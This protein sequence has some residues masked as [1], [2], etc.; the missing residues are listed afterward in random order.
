MVPLVTA[1]KRPSN[2]RIVFVEPSVIDLQPAART[3]IRVVIARGEGFKDRVNLQLLN[4]PF[5]LT[6]PDTGL[7]S[8]QKTWAD[9][10]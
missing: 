7:T 2:V 9:Q 1:T 10:N 3:K 4:L 6:V 8:P 5:G